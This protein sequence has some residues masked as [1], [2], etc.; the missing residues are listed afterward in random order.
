[1]NIVVRKEYKSIKA[2]EQND[3]PD[4]VVLTGKNGTGKTQLLEYLYRSTHPQVD[5]TLDVPL[6]EGDEIPGAVSVL[7]SSG[8]LVPAAPSEIIIDGSTVNNI[9]YRGV[10]APTV[11]VGGKFDHRSLFAKGENIAQK[12]LFYKTHS[13]LVS[14]E[15]KDTEEL[16]R[17]F[18]Q[19]LGV[20]KGS[21]RSDMQIP[22][23]SQEDI[24]LIK[25][26]ETEFPGEDY[27]NDPY[28]Y[29]AYQ[30]SSNTSVFSAELKFLYFQYW[31]RVQAGMPV[32]EK[33]WEAF[34]K[35]GE[36]L[37][38]KYELDEPKLE[39]SKFEV[40]L[41]DKERKTYV[42]LRPESLS[43]GEKVIFSL[44]VAMYTTNTSD[45]LPQVIML[46]EPDAYLHPSLSKTLL[47]VIQ[48][49]LIAEHHLKIIIT[50]HS[51]STVAL[52]PED[53]I[54]KM[55]DGVMEKSSKNEA[56][57]SLTAGINTLSV[58]YENVKQV[59]VEADNDNLYLSNVLHHAIARG[60][61]S[62]DIH[63]NFVNVGNET[64]GG[65]S[66]L[67]KVVNDLVTAGNKTVYGIV[68]Y[69]GG[70]QSNSRIRVLG[71]SRRYAID[72][73]Y[74]D[75]LAMALLIVVLEEKYKCLIG[76][77]E[78]DS[79]TGFAKKTIEER[80]T[81]IDAII[82]QLES[83]V[84]IGE[85]TENEPIEYTTMEGVIYYLPAWFMNIQGHKL[86]GY[87]KQ[88]FG[89]LKKYSDEKKLI[90]EICN[91]YDSYPEIIP[92]D[93]IETLQKIAEDRA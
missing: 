21:G 67:E 59:F 10:Q 7:N 42:S 82:K 63:L 34:N 72:N 44:F 87:Y 25:R 90:K 51:P 2:F 83:V 56:I 68:D 33:P 23:L 84:P 15:S 66:V 20:K 12:H 81:L 28:Y 93:I 9:V 26:I 50:T 29:V 8:E 54:Y 55:E 58:Y 70:K 37:N 76:F 1:M 43:S 49:V 48:K 35:M 36:I 11:D 57:R 62:K 6:E 80:Q 18:N 27:A 92:M 19:I 64:Q 45:H 39:E 13:K 61:I 53:S 79:I 89:G 85:R 38:F 3:L 32:R 71:E 5:P 65:C 47:E 75:P 77:T 4:F 69:D 22:V 73:Y 17:A 74:A 86:V 60:M 14:L 78:H 41:R 88:A 46:D 16:T 31:A 91:V 30:K 52:A 24:E 40:R